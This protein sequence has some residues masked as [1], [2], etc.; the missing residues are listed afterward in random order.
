MIAPPEDVGVMTLHKR[1]RWKIIQAPRYLGEDPVLYHQ[2]V[3]STPECPEQSI[4][5][6]AF[7][8][9]VNMGGDDTTAGWSFWVRAVPK[10]RCSQCKK[11]PPD[12]IITTFTLL[13]YDETTAE[14]AKVTKKYHEEPTKEDWW[15][16]S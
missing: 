13:T 4:H 1:G 12:S 5:P 10:W 3:K 16:Q 2:C 8:C 9:E 7:T 6:V 11:T 15:K 14:V